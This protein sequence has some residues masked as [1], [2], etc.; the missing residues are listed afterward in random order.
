MTSI[1]G[2]EVGRSLSA[3]QLARGPRD[4]QE[5]SSRVNEVLARY[6]RWFSVALGK[7]VNE[8]GGKISF[9]RPLFKGY[10]GGVS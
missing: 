5:H 10:F 4:G 3:C 1:M 9:H 7:T 6:T 8:G 2:A